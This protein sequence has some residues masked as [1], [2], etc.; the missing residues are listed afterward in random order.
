MQRTRRRNAALHIAITIDGFHDDVPGGRVTLR[1]SGA[2]IVDYPIVPRVSL[3]A[4]T[5]RIR[6]SPPS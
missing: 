6:E 3:R 4:T 5:K 2:P 1:D